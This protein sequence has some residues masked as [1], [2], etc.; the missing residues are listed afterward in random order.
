R[1]EAMALGLFTQ[2]RHPVVEEIATVAG[3]TVA[4]AGRRHAR[5]VQRF[6]GR[7]YRRQRDDP[8]RLQRFRADDW[9]EV[10]LDQLVREI[11]FLEEVEQRRVA[12]H[13]ALV[14][15][16]ADRDPAPAGHAPDVC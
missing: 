14:E 5:A 9:L 8:F 11:L 3:R 2:E 10:D 4:R 16:A 6:P 7:P 1:W 15:V 13:G 12:V